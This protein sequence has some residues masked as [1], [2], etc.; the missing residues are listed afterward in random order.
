MR[1]RVASMT[2]PRFWSFIKRQDLDNLKIE[3]D[4]KILWSTRT[5]TK[6]FL[7]SGQV[8]NQTPLLRMALRYFIA[9]QIHLAASDL[10]TDSR[11]TANITKN[12]IPTRQSPLTQFA[13][14]LS[15][16]RR[17]S[18]NAGGQP[19]QCQAD[20]LLPTMPEVPY[21]SAWTV[22]KKQQSRGS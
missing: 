17:H 14:R 5:T 2:S 21:R 16:N 3:P 22:Q 15:T 1:Q 13:S 18:K 12:L 20:R 8:R 19:K 9:T 10:R 7:R 11:S 4:I 6:I